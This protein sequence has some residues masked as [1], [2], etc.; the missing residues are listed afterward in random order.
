MDEYEAKVD[1]RSF[2][3]KYEVPKIFYYTPDFVLTESGKIQR[4]NTAAQ[5][6]GQQ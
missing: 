2:L 5:V 6:V 4:E 1:L 3:E